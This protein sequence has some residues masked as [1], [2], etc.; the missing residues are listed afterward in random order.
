MSI[1]GSPAVAWDLIVVGAGSSG[2]ALAARATE[3]GKSVLLVE[4]GP[5]LT[6]KDLPA[7]WRS[8]NPWRAL[9]G[10]PPEPVIVWPHLMATRTDAQAPALYW[11]GLGTGG[12]SMIN[13]QIAIRPPMDDFEDW[14]LEGWSPTDVLPYFSK[15]ESDMEYGHGANHG[16]HGPIPIFRTRRDDW[17]TVDLALAEASENLG[18]PWADDVN[19]PGAVGASRYPINSR[20][21][22]RVSSNDGYL[23]PLRDAENLTILGDSLVDRVLFDG[24]S[25]VGVR[26][27]SRGSEREHRAGTVVLSAGAIHSPTI[28]M[29]SGI[30]VAHRLRDLGIDCLLNLP[31]GEGLQDHPMIGLGMQLTPQAA[32]QHPDDRHTNVTRRTTS[33]VVG[34]PSKDLQ[35]V[36]MNQNVLAMESAD[37]NVS[38]GG[39]GVWLNRTTSRGQVIMNSPDP[40]EQPFVRENM[41][42]TRDDLARLRNGV[43]T[44]I[45][46]GRQDV[47]KS[48]CVEPIEVTNRDLFDAAES[49]DAAL[50]EYMRL[51]AAD[52][53]HASGT[54]RIGREADPRTVVG[55]DCAVL[56]TQ[57]LY[58]VDASIFPFV[59][60]ANTHLASVMVGELMADRIIPTL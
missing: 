53:Q 52:T 45:E 59:P 17:G 13:G 8:P 6:S 57:N 39:F 38:R 37:T 7:V 20:D 24:T 31:V 22:S 51:T 34:A 50:N 56:G 41:L 9:L 15:L 29:R 12:S 60:R 42:S 14:A 36:S 23:E 16:S 25:A 44:L 19:E 2:C 5:N 18:F 40:T 48:I 28:L 27:I 32:I 46:L 49:A 3:A 55:T 21:G 1:A 58:V 10:A 30:G 33:N 26:T 43:R 4:A 35:F 47:V 54:C 11:R